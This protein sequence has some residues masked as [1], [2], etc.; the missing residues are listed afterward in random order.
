MGIVRSSEG[1]GRSGRVVPA[2]LFDHAAAAR[3]RIAAAEQEADE[4][5]AVARAE[6]EVL[7]REARAAGRE[8]GVAE[9]SAALVRAAAE[10][11][12][13]LS[14]AEGDLVE[15]A[16]AVAER[17]VGAAAER[18]IVVAI[19][20]R[21]LEAAR[22]RS[23]VTLRAHPAD[24]AVLGAAEAELSAQLARAPGVAL[25][26]D[27]AVARGGV[28]VETEAGSVDA[29]LAAQLGALRRAVTG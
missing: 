22:D 28:I 18:G 14:S 4:I 29:T 3:G 21:A 12:R 5:R 9:A 19:A 27:P 17:V 10:R 11:D 15:L 2:A 6:A 16:F 8:E 13:L 20:R 23:H 1:A 24:L 26:G 7:R 25:R